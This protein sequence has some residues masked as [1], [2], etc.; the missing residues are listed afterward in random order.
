[1]LKTAI[2]RTT[3]AGILKALA[4]RHF[5]IMSYDLPVFWYRGG[6]YRDARGP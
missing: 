2:A 5:F 3:A 6:P 4:V 1:V